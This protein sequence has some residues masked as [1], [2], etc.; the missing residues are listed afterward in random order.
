MTNTTGNILIIKDVYT[1][2]VL[3]TKSITFL[4]FTLTFTNRNI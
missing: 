3:V 4:G 2:G 1:N